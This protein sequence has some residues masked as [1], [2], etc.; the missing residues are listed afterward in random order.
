MLRGD[1]AMGLMRPP[2]SGQG[3]GLPTRSEREIFRACAGHVLR[4]RWRAIKA[5]QAAQA[6][7]SAGKGKSAEYFLS[8]F[9]STDLRDPEIQQAP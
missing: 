2:R 3:R 9:W 1:V 6:D 5:I 8:T 4:R 7:S